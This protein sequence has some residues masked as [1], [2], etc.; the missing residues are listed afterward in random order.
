MQD[1][2]FAPDELPSVFFCQV[3]SYLATKDYLRHGR[4]VRLFGVDS[5]ELTT[6]HLQ[7]G[8]VTFTIDIDYWEFCTRILGL[9]HARQLTKERCESVDLTH[10][11][12]DR[13]FKWYR[14]EVEFCPRAS[15]YLYQSFSMKGERYFKLEAIDIIQ[16][17]PD[18]P[19]VLAPEEASSS[20][21]LS[22]LELTTSLEPKGAFQNNYFSFDAFHVG[23]G[24]CSLVHNGYRGILLDVGAGKPVT[25]KA[26]LEE[27]IKNDLRAAVKQLASVV[28]VISHPDSDHWRILAWDDAIRAKVG[29]IFVPSGAQSLA[30]TDRE[31]IA[32]VK[33]LGDQVWSLCLGNRLHLIRSKPASY[34]SNGDCLVA[35]F[36]RF[37]R[38][39]LAAGDYV[40][41]RFQSDSN[42]LIKS[43]HA[44]SYDAVVVPHHG[45]SASAN[46]IV[47]AA[48][49]AKAFFS[50][51]THQGYGHPTSQSLDAHLNANYTNIEDR[52][53]PDIVKVNLL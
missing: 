30:L 11:D 15:S 31:L 38:R 48:R 18:M 21:I 7:N 52:A 8:V 53:N 47:P 10:E 37:G 3:E 20:E 49:D 43:L 16:N 34:D 24:M 35:I 26:Y 40:Y 29:A 46:A 12:P 28:A 36:E 50:A 51:G 2:N 22:F 41:Q 4:C 14:I 9:K 5:R 23:Q 25:R 45:D 17:S 19:T 1:D 39:V 27:T 33:S 32:K 44:R 13:R 6:S 42:A